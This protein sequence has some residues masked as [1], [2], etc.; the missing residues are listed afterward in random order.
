[1]NF[2]C[3][4]GE[5]AAVSSGD[6]ELSAHVLGLCNIIWVATLCEEWGLSVRFGSL[7]DSSAA[8]GV[9]S[10][11]GYSKLKHVQANSLRTQ[12]LAI[13]IRLSRCRQ[14]FMGAELGRR[15]GLLCTEATP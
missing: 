10:R 8:R 4:L 7:S 13:R 1:M 3:R 14:G 6:S 15:F 11:F 5:V 12:Y 9:A 2:A